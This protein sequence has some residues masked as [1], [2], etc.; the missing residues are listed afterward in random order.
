MI[1]RSNRVTSIARLATAALGAFGVLAT[2]A[3]AQESLRNASAAS[4]QSLAASEQSVQAAALMTASGLQ[5]AMG[6]TALPLASAGAVLDGAGQA[7]TGMATALW[8]GANATLVVDDAIMV[9]GPA[10]DA[11]MAN[12]PTAD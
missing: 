9:A 1:I 10:P 7:S 3:T 6:V 12:T 5:V 11:A 4:N 8:E 2:P